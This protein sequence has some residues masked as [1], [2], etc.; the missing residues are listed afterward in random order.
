MTRGRIVSDHG[1]MNGSAQPDSWSWPPLDGQR[2][3]RAGVQ[4]PGALEEGW[5]ARSAGTS[6]V[7]AESVMVL[8]RASVTG[9]S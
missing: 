8:P 1:D 6:P 2:P 3:W 5:R 4:P 9:R 7:Q